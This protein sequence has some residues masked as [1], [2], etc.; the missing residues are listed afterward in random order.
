MC[1]QRVTL[2][3]YEST[4]V[5]DWLKG[6]PARK[7]LVF[8]DPKCGVRIKDVGIAGFF[9][10]LKEHNST[11]MSEVLAG[12]SWGLEGDGSLLSSQ[13]TNNVQTVGI[14]ADLERK[15]VVTAK[16]VLWVVL[17]LDCCRSYR[18]KLQNCT[19]NKHTFSPQLPIPQGSN[20]ISLKK[21]ALFIKN[22]PRN[23]M[24]LLIPNRYPRG[25]KVCFIPQGVIWESNNTGH[26]IPSTCLWLSTVH[27]SPA[28]EP[29]IFSGKMPSLRCLC[30]VLACLCL[31]LSFNT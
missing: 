30:V 16:G 13:T 21:N 27:C 26:S 25:E 24:F 4:W 14:C 31:G 28:L 10:V 20:W 15:I 5:V 19:G 1:L 11:K 7:E 3:A 12:F 9:P 23:S 2:M 18:A 29:H 8:S 17:G 6:Y 22:F